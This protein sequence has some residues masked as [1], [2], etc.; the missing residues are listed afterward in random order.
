MGI[1][2]L[3]QGLD[4]T[5]PKNPG[6]SDLATQDPYPRQGLAGTW[7]PH[8]CLQ[9]TITAHPN[10]LGPH[11]MPYNEAWAFFGLTAPAAL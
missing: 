1:Q 10:L 8:P 11:A 9:V 5:S 4:H 6:G 7:S 3:G 2:V